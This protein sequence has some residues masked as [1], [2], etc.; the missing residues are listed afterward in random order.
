MKDFRRLEVWEKSHQMVLAVYRATVC[1]PKAEEF[2]LKSQLR[3]CAAS[4]PA[5][6]AEGCGRNTDGD[7][8]RF[9]QIAMGSATE[10]DY[11]LLLAKDLKFLSPTDYDRLA[12][13]VHRVKSMLASLL[14]KVEADRARI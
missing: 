6:I 14:R 1:F 9:L 12:S 2:G 13:D 7:F 4:I 3:R 11:H 10:L 5:N 8:S